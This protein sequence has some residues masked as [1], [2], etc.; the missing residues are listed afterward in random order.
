MLYHTF[1]SISIVSVVSVVIEF[2]KISVLFVTVRGLRFKKRLYNGSHHYYYYYYQ[3]WNAVILKLIN[4][5]KMG[6]GKRSEII[7]S[8]ALFKNV[9]KL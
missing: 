5:K 3:V 8:V 4:R 6:R 7:K 9:L 1:S 2:I